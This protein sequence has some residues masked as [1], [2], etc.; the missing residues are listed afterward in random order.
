MRG[1]TLALLLCACGSSGAAPQ[2]QPQPPQ[3]H[4]LVVESGTGDGTYAAGAA[5]A[6]AADPAPAGSTFDRW[7]GDTAGVADVNAAAT[8]LTMPSADTTVVA[9]YRAVPPPAPAPGTPGEVEATVETEPVPGGGDAADDLC[10]WIHPTAP[11]R[12]TIIACDK[13]G[14]ALLV[15]DLEGNQIQRVSSGRMNNVDLREGFALGGS[16]V[17]LVVATNRTDD[18]LEAYAVDPATRQLAPK[19][20]IAAGITVYG[21]CLY[22]SEENGDTYAFVNS[23]GGDVEQW[24]LADDG[25]GGIAGTRVRTFEVGSITEGCV[26]DDE[27]GRFYIGE[28]TQGIWRYG[29]EPGDGDARVQVDT[30]GGGGHI[31]ADI[32]GLAL[33]RAGSGTGYLIASSQGNNAFAV[34]EREG[35]NAYV[36][37]FRIV[38]GAIDAVSDTDGIDVTSASLGPAFQGGLFVAQDGDNDDGN[39]NFKLVPWTR[40]AGA[41][42]PPLAIAP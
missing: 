18:T 2:P 1:F 36:G 3:L 6:I 23:S 16:V 19:G 14:D 13:S 29:A 10:F 34:Y 41:F 26:A 8:T 9:S 32:E 20:S 4:D 24:R 40:I 21:L 7:S 22:R 25:A 31:E 39:Q 11:D 30:T 12:S 28:E 42:T 38:A 5:I 37:T 15:Y 33:Y 35:A 17:A 27:L